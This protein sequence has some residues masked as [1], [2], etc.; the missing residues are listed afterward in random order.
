M[1]WVVVGESVAKCCFNGE[2]LAVF[3]KKYMFATEKAGAVPYV[4]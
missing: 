1:R 2:D 3:V 4:Y